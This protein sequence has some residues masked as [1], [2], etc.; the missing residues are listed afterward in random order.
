MLNSGLDL[1]G[2]QRLKV[3]IIDLQTSD[4]GLVFQNVTLKPERLFGGARTKSK[5]V[6]GMQMMTRGL[7]TRCRRR[8][9]PALHVDEG[10]R[11]AM[12]MMDRAGRLTLEDL[13][14]KRGPSFSKV[15]LYRPMTKGGWTGGMDGISE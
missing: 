15:L 4:P 11:L 9:V 6:T 2:I 10:K 5:W 8:D 14:G 13:S 12:M 3:F 1:P 7:R